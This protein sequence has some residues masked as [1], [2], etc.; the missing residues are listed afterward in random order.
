MCLLLANSI[1]A[2]D[3][4]HGLAVSINGHPVASFDSHTDELFPLM[5]VVKFPAV[6][7]FLV[8]VDVD[9]GV[10]VRPIPGFFTDT[11]QSK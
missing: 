9:T 8:R 4:R 11:D 6:K 2:A 1:H 7:E 5:S 3:L 10:Y